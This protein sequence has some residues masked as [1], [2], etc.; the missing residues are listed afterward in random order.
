MPA[1]S[2][3]RHNRETAASVKPLTLPPL[4]RTRLAQ[5]AASG[6]IALASIIGTGCGLP[7]SP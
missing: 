3:R 7:S 5:S 1:A 4:A 6:W 2:M